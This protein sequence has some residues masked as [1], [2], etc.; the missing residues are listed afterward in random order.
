MA[1]N[2]ILNEKAFERAQMRVSA[3]NAMTLQ[4]TINKT[5]FLLLLCVAGGMITWTNYQSWMGITWIVSI[6]AFILAIVMTFKP[7]LS[8]MLSPLYALGQGMFLGAVSAAYNVQFK[9]IVF[10]AVAITVLVFFVM[11]FLYK[12]RIIRVT[13]G[14]AIGIVSAT[15]AV[16]LFYII[17]LVLGLFGVNTSYLSSSSP[18]S[19]GISLVICGIAAFN[20]L[21]DFN[22]IDQMTGEYTAP[23]YM[24]WYAAFGLVLTLI[25]L[26]IEVLRLLSKFQSRN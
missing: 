9:G 21:L 13:R 22:M 26:Y 8:P 1:A 15:G 14:L 12:T 4:G 10:Q 20:F 3:Q 23:K 24:E 25:W 7:A 17:S 5:F 6:V 2:P 19:I 11:L 16:A 18:L